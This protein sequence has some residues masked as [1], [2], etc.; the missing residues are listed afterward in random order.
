L[1][2]AIIDVTSIIA[3]YNYTSKCTDVMGEVEC[4]LHINCI[5]LI[6]YGHDCRYSCVL[7][8]VLFHDIL[9]NNVNFCDVFTQID[10][11]L[12]TRVIHDFI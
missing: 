12:E 7:Q 10:Y 8:M 5:Y 11:S 1:Y 9:C 3:I 4:L 2:I 6:F